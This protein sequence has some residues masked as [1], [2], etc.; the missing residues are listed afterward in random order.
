MRA[1]EFIL[2]GDVIQ[3]P[4]G[5]QSPTDQ[6]PINTSKPTTVPLYKAFGQ[7][8]YVQMR[9]AGF[10]FDEKPDYFDSIKSEINVRDLPKIS[11]LI[12]G[13]LNS[14]EAVNILTKYKDG[15]FYPLLD[16]KFE[17]LKN[18]EEETF[19]VWLPESNQRFLANR[20][21]AKTYIRM[22]ARLVD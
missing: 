9:E 10:N 11:Q 6:K 13:K 14:Y 20:T 12:G 1:K 3:G 8:E 4:W 19:I 16:A 7:A 21:G 5:K 2:E 22:W 17:N 15:K 18:P